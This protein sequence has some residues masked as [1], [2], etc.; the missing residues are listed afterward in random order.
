MSD[1]FNIKRFAAYAVKTYRENTSKY[2]MYALLVLCLQAGLMIINAISYE[3]HFAVRSVMFVTW[4]SL[5]LV[6]LFVFSEM[7]PF[8]NRHTAPAS[9][10]FAVSYLEKY[11]L[12]IL[13]TTVLFMIVYWGI[14][15]LVTLTASGVFGYGDMAEYWL[16]RKGA[17]RISTVVDVYITFIPIAIFAGMTNI[18]N[19]LLAFL[20]VTVVAI[21]LLGSPVY[22]PWFLNSNIFEGIQFGGHFNTIS[23]TVESGGTVMEYATVPMFGR[24]FSRFSG[25]GYEFYIWALLLSVTGYFKFRERQIK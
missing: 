10:T 12:L 22:L 23:A 5:I 16:D 14:F 15:F 6:V 17:L 4:T 18:K 25:H 13:N 8:R 11:L 20:I 2:M 9:N 1:I 7:K 3:S 21:P 24:F 19:H